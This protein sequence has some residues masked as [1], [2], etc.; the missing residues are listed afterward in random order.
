MTLIVK[1]FYENNLHCYLQHEKS[2]FI[3]SQIINQILDNYKNFEKLVNV[4]LSIIENIE[5]YIT[6]LIFEQISVV[7][8]SNLDKLSSDDAKQITNLCSKA[9]NNNKV[10][11]EILIEYIQNKFVEIFNLPIDYVEIFNLPIDYIENITID[12]IAKYP[13]GFHDEIQNI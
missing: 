1:D 9:K 3:V 5:G 12:I 7:E 2:E 4:E 11:P 10:G 13:T 6:Y 8:D